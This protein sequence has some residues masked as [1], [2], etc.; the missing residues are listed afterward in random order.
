M[1]LLDAGFKSLGTFLGLRTD[2]PVRE[3][4]ARIAWG[5]FETASA[6]MRQRT[7][8]ISDSVTGQGCP[9]L[10]LVT[11]YSAPLKPAR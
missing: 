11:W 10:N 3:M 8:R 6:K 7:R 2:I 4:P 9:G 5:L 1:S